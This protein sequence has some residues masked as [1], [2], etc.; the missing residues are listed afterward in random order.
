MLNG[1]SVTV[2]FPETPIIFT[3]GTLTTLSKNKREFFQT[4]GGPLLHVSLASDLEESGVLAKCRI[5]TVLC[6]N[7][8]TLV[9]EMLSTENKKLQMFKIALSGM[10]PSMI[11]ALE[12]LVTLHTMWKHKVVIFT[13]Y[14]PQAEAL[15]YIFPSAVVVVGS[16]ILEARENSINRYEAPVGKDHP[17]VLGTTSLW[18][19]GW[20][21]DEVT[22]VIS[23]GIDS[24]NIIMQRFGRSVRLLECDFGIKV[25]FC[26][27]LSD[28]RPERCP[29]RKW[30]TGDTI[31]RSAVV[32]SKKFNTL[33]DN[34]YRDRLNV[35]TLDS[36]RSSVRR[37]MFE[38]APEAY[39][40]DPE[41]EI[42]RSGS[43]ALGIDNPIA[44]LHHALFLFE[45]TCCMS[46]KGPEP[47]VA[48]C[49]ANAANAAKPISKRPKTATAVQIQVSVGGSSSSSKRLVAQFRKQQAT[50]SSGGKKG[51]SKQ[52][53]AKEECRVNLDERESR[54]LK[55]LM[56]KIISTAEK[57]IEFE[58][59]TLRHM[60]TAASS[61]EST[62]GQIW[63]CVDSIYSY[64]K[65]VFQ[66]VDQMRANLRNDSC[67]SFG[68]KDQECAFLERECQSQKS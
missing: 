49:R 63:A 56:Q 27:E 26:Y 21:H 66:K 24:P 37:F 68:V 55:G 62:N 22:V 14:V 5:T 13:W 7:E 20:S 9:R 58:D 60:I 48:R 67:E 6:R 41:D 54:D 31:D 64:S 10:L 23:L 57:T 19:R 51:K 47:A 8:S 11:E 25:A 35:M 4:F 1:E 39:R 30:G 29:P 45:R 46:K 33:S 52:S 53:D 2:P 65:G 61:P 43:I 18:Q 36:L 34:G 50:A 40:L 16:D 12:M 38:D 28:D 44:G 17:F 32:D 3:S 42:C 59:E 15:R